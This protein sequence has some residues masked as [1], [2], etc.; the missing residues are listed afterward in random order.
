MCNNILSW[1]G[2]TLLSLQELPSKFMVAILSS[3]LKPY[4]PYKKQPKEAETMY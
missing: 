4:A 1:Y 3:W 2:Y